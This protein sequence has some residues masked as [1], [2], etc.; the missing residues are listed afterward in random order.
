MADAKNTYTQEDKME[1]VKEDLG[2]I[3]KIIFRRRYK[4][5]HETLKD[6]LARK[7][8]KKHNVHYYAARIAKSYPGVESRRL[9]A[10]VKEA[11]DP[12]ILPKSGAGQ[13]GT[14]TLV[15]SYV[16]AT[17]GQVNPRMKKFKEYID[18][19]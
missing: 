5:A 10:M 13:I 9:A 7:T 2:V 8:G 18:N 6:V 16:K 15:N 1:H 19:R 14:D 4:K 12:D 3:G 11:V 17:P